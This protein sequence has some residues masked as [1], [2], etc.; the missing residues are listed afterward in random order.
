M[1]DNP[2]LKVPPASRGNRTHARFP[3]RSGGTLRRGAIVNS[4]LA[5]GIRQ[6]TLR[7]GAATP[8]RG[9]ARS[10]TGFVGRRLLSEAL[11]ALSPSVGGDVGELGKEQAH[12]GLGVCTERDEGE[13]EPVE[14]V[15]SASCGSTASARHISPSPACGSGGNSA[16]GRR[17]L[18][19]LEVAQ[20]LARH[21]FGVRGVVERL[22]RRPACIADSAQG[23]QNRR[24]VGRAIARR[25]QVGVVEM[26]MRQVGRVADESARAHRR[27]RLTRF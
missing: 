17:A 22:Q 25:A 3:S 15:E 7:A 14:A 1:P 10:E 5:I 24:E 13:Q 23:A 4:A 21:G 8:P 12:L 2:L 27:F 16:Q 19:A 26:H 6:G 9:A 18:Q 20:R 11:E